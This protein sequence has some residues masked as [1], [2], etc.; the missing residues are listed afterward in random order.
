MHEPFLDTG[1]QRE[2]MARFALCFNTQAHEDGGSYY[3]QFREGL[4]ELWGGR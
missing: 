3:S 2:E 1:N 4:A